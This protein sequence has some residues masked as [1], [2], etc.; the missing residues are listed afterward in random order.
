M[1]SAVKAK[2]SVAASI[3]SA[4]ALSAGQIMASG[5]TFSF[6]Y[7][8][9]SNSPSTTFD[10]SNIVRSSLT[11]GPTF[12]YAWGAEANIRFKELARKEVMDELTPVEWSEF[13]SLAA[14][15]RQAKFPLSA[16]QILWQRKQNALTEKL[17][18]VFKEYVEFHK[19]SQ[20]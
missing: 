20:S 13:N 15:R 19:N 18:E 14:L 12:H 9:V 6:P 17:L 5:T 1:T 4:L 3:G 10:S 2:V 11:L 7:S 16:D 8:F